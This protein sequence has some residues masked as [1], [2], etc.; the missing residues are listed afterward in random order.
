MTSRTKTT[1]GTLVLALILA[2]FASAP[3][4]DVAPRADRT[5]YITILGAQGPVSSGVRPVD[6]QVLEDGVEREITSVE[7]ATGP[8]STVVLLDSTRDASNAIVHL[9]QATNDFAA[10]MFAASPTS[11]IALAEFGG[12][13]MVTQP[14]TSSADDIGSAVSRLVANTDGSSLLNEGLI[15][16]SRE[17]GS[18]E[19][20]R[21]FIVT[22]NMEPTKEFSQSNFNDVANAVRESGATVYSIQILRG[23]TDRDA[24]REQ[25]LGALTA[26]S[27]GMLRTTQVPQDNLSGLLGSIAQLATTQFAVTFTRPDGEAPAEKTEVSVVGREGFNVFT[28]MWSGK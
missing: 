16:V 3:N 19:S 2:P 25:L 7:P 23:G 20:P 10:A 28:N 27:G 22:V 5:V 18:E 24:G 14:F 12:R 26:N 4:A 6:L 8:T 15:E 13:A 21:R 1:L 11:R 9:R 17:L